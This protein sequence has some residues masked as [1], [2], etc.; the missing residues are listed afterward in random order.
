MRMRT[1]ELMPGEMADFILFLPL[2]CVINAS[3]ASLTYF[4]F[5][6]LLDRARP[7]VCREI[8]KE[9]IIISLTLH[10]GRDK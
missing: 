9:P 8:E 1:F 2:L 4:D 5:H 7:T 3:S 10:N 6:R